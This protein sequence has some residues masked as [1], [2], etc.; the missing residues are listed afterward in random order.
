MQLPEVDETYLRDKGHKWQLF[1]DGKGAC[2]VLSDFAVAADLYD[3]DKTD[4]MIRIPAQYNIAGLDMFYVSPELKLSAT[5]SY[6]DR[7]S[8]FE[9]HIERRWQ[10]FSRHLTTTP[11]RPGVDGLRMF[12]AL[13]QKE[14]QAKA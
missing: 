4:L 6:P 10:R 1:P 9:T 12:M 14:L 5:G 2:L 8:H 7:A 11:W 3:R 13:I